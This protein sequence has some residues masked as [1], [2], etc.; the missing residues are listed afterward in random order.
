MV[1]D[2]EE[3]ANLSR[4]KAVTRRFWEVVLK[5]YAVGSQL[6]II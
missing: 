4:P 1:D 2:S 5:H 6:A 3:D